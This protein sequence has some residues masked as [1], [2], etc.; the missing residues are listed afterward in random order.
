MKKKLYLL[1]FVTFSLLMSSC[2]KDSESSTEE[3]SNFLKVETTQYELTN[4]LAEDY[5]QS[6]NNNIYNID[7][8]LLTAEF[9]I[10]G[11]QYTGN[12]RGM[13]FEAFSSVANKLET[14]VYQYNNTQKS[15]SFDDAVYYDNTDGKDLEIE[16]KSGTITITKSKNDYYELTF[17]CVDEQDR[18]ISGRY[19]GNVN[20]VSN[21]MQ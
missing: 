16:I 17:E 4:G 2:T 21:L 11:E 6:S 7:L 18:K 9:T 14:G 12:G 8:T 19:F 20:Y 13:Y 3:K 15:Q 5:S 10:N 1:A